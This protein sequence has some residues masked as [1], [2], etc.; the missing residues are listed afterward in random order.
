MRLISEL[1]RTDDEN[2]V[3]TL[4]ELD[5]SETPLSTEACF[6]LASGLTQQLLVAKDF[7]YLKYELQLPIDF[8]APFNTPQ[9]LLSKNKLR[10]LPP[11]RET[12]AGYTEKLK[13][14]NPLKKLRLSKT[15]LT[16]VSLAALAIVLSRL[17]NIQQIDLSSNFVSGKS[18]QFLQLFDN[19]DHISSLNING[20]QIPHTLQI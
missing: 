6:V 11:I 19:S 18:V 5:L 20:N 10:A 7:E 4:E 2:F 8:P 9:L 13:K 17:P 12:P 15:H 16:D 14:S 1:F 3:P